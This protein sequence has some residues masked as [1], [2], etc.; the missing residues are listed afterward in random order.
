MKRLS[1]IA[2]LLLPALA[3]SAQGLSLEEVRADVRKAAAWFRG[4]EYNEPAETP[5]APAGFKPFNISTY[6]RH[7][8]RLYSK[9]SLYDQMHDLMTG[10][11]A[12]GQLTPLGEQLLVRS[13]AVFH[14]V[15]G[16]AYDLTELGQEQ[17]RQVAD[18]IWDAWKGVFKDRRTIVARSTQTNRTILSMAAALDEYRLKDS[19]LRIK[20]DASAADMGVLNPTS[21]YNPRAGERDWSRAFEADTA[22]WNPP[23]KRLWQENLDPQSYFGRFFKDPSVVL[24]VFKNY[25]N[26][27]RMFYFYLS[28]SE[29]LGE[30]ESLMYLMAPDDAFKAWECE[31]FRMYSC[32]GATPLY[33]GRNWALEEALVRDFL[34]YWEEDIEGGDVAARLRFGHD[35]KISGTLALLDAA[36]WNITESDP[37]KVKE[38]Y[39]FGKLPMA[40]TLLFALY[41]NSEGEVLVRCTLDEQPV[42][43][44]IPCFIDGRGRVFADFY[45][46]DD[47]RGHVKARLDIADK[48]LETT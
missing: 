6:A 10:A 29:A 15:R 16:R 35:Y 4:H 47:F 28:F 37:R 8:A 21:K 39:D 1:L 32:C 26:A 18:R 12:D 22:R 25:I 40:S 42:H 7:G 11:K 36:R 31:N 27:A 2:A 24:K 17:H 41:R 38:I 19:R 14:R 48:I 5:K 45:R 44:P 33:K 34:K 13:E 43:F 30:D 20:F 3:L 9:E 23:F 46:W